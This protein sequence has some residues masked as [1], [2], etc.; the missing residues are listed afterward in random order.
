MNYAFVRALYQFTR[1]CWHLRFRVTNNT[2]QESS[3]I[4]CPVGFFSQVPPTNSESV[5]LVS[6][7]PTNTLVQPPQ[8]SNTP[9]DS[10]SSLVQ[11]TDL[12]IGGGEAAR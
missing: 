9:G 10:P 12:F 8:C 3:C 7:P 4:S 2:Y 1:D 11:E 6:Q 5:T